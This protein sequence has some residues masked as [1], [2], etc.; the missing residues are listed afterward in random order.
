[1][2]SWITESIDTTDRFHGCFLLDRN[3]C[4]SGDRDNFDRYIESLEMARDSKKNPVNMNPYTGGALLTVAS[5]KEWKKGGMAGVMDYI[6]KQTKA[7]K[8]SSTAVNA[9]STPSRV[10]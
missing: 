9:L 3:W 7:N 6:Y 8:S 1:M 10:F 5:W 4:G 2:I